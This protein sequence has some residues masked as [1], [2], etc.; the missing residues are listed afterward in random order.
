MNRQQQLS[1]SVS[2]TANDSQDLIGLLEGQSLKYMQ[3]TAYVFLENGIDEQERISFRELENRAKKI[4]AFLQKDFKKGDRCVLLF[5]TGIDFVVSL[6][7]VIL[8]GLIAVPAYP[9]RR[10]SSSGRFWSILEDSDASL[11][12]CSETNAKNLKRNFGDDVRMQACPVFEYTDLL[13]SD[14]QA[15]E[16]PQ[17][18]PDDLAILQY[19]SGSTGQPRGVMVSHQNI[20]NNFTVVHKAFH[21]DEKLVVV[22]WL[23]NFHDMGLFGTTLQSLFAGGM[24]VIIPPQ[25]FIK[26]PLLWLKAITKYKAITTG[27]PNFALDYCCNKIT[28]DQKNEIDLSTLL[29]F[30]CGAEPIHKSTFDRFA[31]E[32]NSCGFKPEMFYPTYGLAES[33]LMVVGPDHRDKPLYYPANAAT[34]EN[35]NRITP[36][37]ENQNQKDIVACG[38]PWQGNRILIVQPESREELEYGRIGEIWVSGPSVCQGYWNNAQATQEVFGA[39]VKDSD[40]RPFLRTGDLG[41]VHNGQLYITGRHKDMI[42]IR[43]QNFYPQDLEKSIADSH[44]AL[45][46]YA[47]AAFS[48]NMAREEHLVIVQEVKRTHIPSL[49][50]E[51]VFEAIRQSMATDFELQAFSIVLIRTGSIPK[52][53]SGK[54]QRRACKKAFIDHELNVVASWEMDLSAEYHAINLDTRDFSEEDVQKWLINWMSAKVKIDPKTVDP[55]KSILAYGLDSL[56][57]VELEREISLQFDI[58]WSVSDF[59]ESNKISDLAKTGYQLLKEK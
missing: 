58:E 15:W 56:A 25:V 36:A 2:K 13:V 39:F 31:R 59:L 47:G 8:A 11:I 22:G 44:E 51:E 26:N 17:T 28:D 4:A 42:V 48:V 34:I 41:F 24:S 33:T 38:F 19:T 53:T 32:F 14:P 6:F 35:E 54:I 49:N 50:E 52:T 29:V 5:P 37:A 27:S 18:S 23:P 3:K 40:E 30:F 55:E 21:H 1:S 43:G 57:A 7:G 12:L 10:N 45:A 46:E 20:I 9:P 16:R